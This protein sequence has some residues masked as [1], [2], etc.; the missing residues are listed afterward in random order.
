MIGHFV[1]SMFPSKLETQSALFVFGLGLVYMFIGDRS[2]LFAKM[3]KQFDTFTFTALCLFMTFLGAVTLK[4]DHGETNDAGFLNRDQ[5]DEWK[6][7]MQLAILIYHFVGASRIAGIYN[8]VRVL[9]A[10]YLFQTGYGHFFYFYKKADFGIARVLN[11]MV[12]LNLLTC[13]LTYLM[14]TD[15]LFYYFS[16]LCT[17]WFAVIWITMRI[18][19]SFNK[20]S[21]F[22]VLKMIIMS[23]ITTCI[24]HVPGI[25]ETVF[26]V[27]EFLFKVKWD[28]VDWRF[29][30]GL[31][32]WIVYIGMLC[33]LATIKC[34]EYKVSTEY[35]RTWNIAR[36]TSL[37]L[38]LAGFV[39]FFVFELTQTK[40]SYT[41]YHPY[42]SWIP[43]L[44]FVV[45]RNFMRF[46]RNTYSRFFAFVGKFS[47]ET[48]IG[49]FHMWLAADTRGL[50]VIVPNATWVLKSTLG[51]YINLCLSTVVFFFVCY[52]LSH[53]TGTLT[54]WICSGAVEQQ[55]QDQQQKTPAY[56]AVPLLPT[57]SPSSL[58]IEKGKNQQTAAG[59]AQLEIDSSDSE[60]DLDLE[61]TWQETPQ[62]S[63]YQRV[64]H[65]VIDNYWVRSVVCLVLLGVFNR[66]C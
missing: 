37:A 57:T 65:A 45:M 11:I 9:V 58:L 7:W 59:P 29:R 51:W 49:Q 13:V 23:V 30:L 52:H 12:R 25:L 42:I 6:G 47:L 41:K 48:Y 17:F 63:L 60:S 1:R 18:L 32:A 2:Q 5:T 56:D 64:Y 33:A 36:Y 39:G 14:K 31:D 66:F 50:L 46:E 62:P 4:S 28:V 16:P 35:T 24:I 3:D 27:L 22:V 40:A 43:I 61:E 20:K 26:N 55:K 53:T 54:K 19:P 10:A 38:S 44:S 8:P 21:W 15:Y 34:A